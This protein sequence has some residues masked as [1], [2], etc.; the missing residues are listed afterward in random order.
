VLYNN[1]SPQ[2]IRLQIKLHFANMKL[3]S[4]LQMFVNY[5]NNIIRCLYIVAE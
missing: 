4:L 2:S 1:I 3:E 5:I